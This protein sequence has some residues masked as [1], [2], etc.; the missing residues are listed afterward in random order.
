MSLSIPK[1]MPAQFHWIGIPIE[2]G[3]DPE[4]KVYFHIPFWLS[5]QLLIIGGL[6][7]FHF[8]ELLFP[9]PLNIVL[10]H[11]QNVLKMMKQYYTVIP[12][13]GTKTNSQPNKTVN[14]SS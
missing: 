5:L 11:H 9:S 2:S 6:F 7:L 1:D 3:E 8:S 4:H 10:K 13:P 14:R 12:T